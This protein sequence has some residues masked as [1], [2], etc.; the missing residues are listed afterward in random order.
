L[1]DKPYIHI[2][3][4]IIYS[5]NKEPRL[6]VFNPRRVLLTQLSWLKNKYVWIFLIFTDVVEDIGCGFFQSQRNILITFEVFA[7]QKKTVKK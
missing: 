7:E 5:F 6:I 1:K 3:I 2:I 4:I